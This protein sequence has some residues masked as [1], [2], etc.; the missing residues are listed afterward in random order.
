ML[1]VFEGKNIPVAEKN[2]GTVCIFLAFMTNYV[3]KSGK[4]SWD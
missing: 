1:K 2:R 3:L 4:S